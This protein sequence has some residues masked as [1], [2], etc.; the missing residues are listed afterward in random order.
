MAFAIKFNDFTFEGVAR[1]QETDSQRVSRQSYPRR[2]A[3]LLHNFAFRDRRFVTLS[4]EVFF[5]TAAELE[6][7][8]ENMK[9]V[10]F[11]GAGRLYWLDNGR[12][13]TAILTSTGGLHDYARLPG[14]SRQ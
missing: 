2:H 10:I 14:R 9:A 13:L 3:R 8:L 4:C 12:Y 5:D 1:W 6:T 7:Y 11:S